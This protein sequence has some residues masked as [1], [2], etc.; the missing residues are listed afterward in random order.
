M[1]LFLKVDKYIW[2]EICDLQKLTCIR[3]HPELKK[4]FVSIFGDNSEAL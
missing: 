1:N 2:N 3:I 4:D